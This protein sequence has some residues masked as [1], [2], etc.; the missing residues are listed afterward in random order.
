MRVKDDVFKLDIQMSQAEFTVKVVER[1]YDL[2]EDSMTESLI[3]NY[4]TLRHV[5]E[6][7][8]PRAVLENNVGKWLF[9]WLI[10]L[11]LVLCQLELF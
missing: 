7:V 2:S 3:A 5:G 6:Q 9:L 10:A 4:L 8:H 1:M 11:T